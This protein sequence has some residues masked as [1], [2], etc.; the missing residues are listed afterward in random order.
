MA[1]GTAA[2]KTRAKWQKE[3]AACLFGHPG[4]AGVATKQFARGWRPQVLLVQRRQGFYVELQGLV[5]LAFD[6]ELGLELFDEEL[7]TGDFGF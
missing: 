6:L 7:E 4:Q 3:P 5:V 1:V 2:F